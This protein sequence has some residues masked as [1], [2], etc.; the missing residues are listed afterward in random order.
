[1]TDCYGFPLG[2]SRENV[3]RF[4]TEM[5]SLRGRKSNQSKDT[6]RKRVEQWFSNHSLYPISFPLLFRWSATPNSPQGDWKLRLFAGKL[7]AKGK[8]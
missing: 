5:D 1:M 8:F 2:G 7:L 6:K 3:N 4:D